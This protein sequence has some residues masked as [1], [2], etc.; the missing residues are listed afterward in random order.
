MIECRL[1]DAALFAIV[2]LLHLLV[3][4]IKMTSLL[5]Q[6]R[7]QLPNVLINP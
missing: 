5:D 6:V 4:W 2:R 3:S 7:P 1:K